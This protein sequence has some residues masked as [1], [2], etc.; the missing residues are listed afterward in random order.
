M[1]RFVE[2]EHNRAMRDYERRCAEAKASSPAPIDELA[3]KLASGGEKAI[4]DYEAYTEGQFLAD[5]QCIYDYEALNMRR[6]AARKARKL[7]DEIST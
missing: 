3:E 7:L 4:A 5:C 2:S 1:T 6:I